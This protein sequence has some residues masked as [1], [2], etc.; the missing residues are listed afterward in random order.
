MAVTWSPGLKL[1][2]ANPKLIMF[3]GAT[4]SQVQFTTFPS[5]PL[6]SIFTRT[7]GLIQRHSVTVP[8]KVSFLFSYDAFP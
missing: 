4:S 6:T 8:F 3:E 2:A 1:S 7:C 5:S